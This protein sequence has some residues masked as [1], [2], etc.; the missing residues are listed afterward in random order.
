MLIICT[1]VIKY[2]MSIIIYVCYVVSMLESEYFVHRFLD[3]HM[4]KNA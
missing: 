1:A 4:H 2:L 3:M